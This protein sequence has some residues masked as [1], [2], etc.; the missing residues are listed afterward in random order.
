MKTI[1][2]DFDGTLVDV[3]YRYFSIFNEY[4]NNKYSLKIDFKNYIN[5]KRT[6]LK[7]HKILEIFFGE[8]NFDIEEYLIFK[9]LKLEDVEYLNTDKLIGNPSEFAKLCNNLNFKIILLTQR[10]NLNNLKLQLSNLKIQHL[11]KKIVV[12]PPKEGV[13]VKYEYLKHYVDISDIIIGD[14]TSELDAGNILGLSTFFVDTGL[15]D[16]SIVDRGTIFLND[17][18]EVLRYIK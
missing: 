14:S 11:F 12:V 13:N 1:Y 6:G 5:L 16:S 3:N 7:D 15:N 9:R 4:I 2:I 10:N 8:L 18:S 17:Y